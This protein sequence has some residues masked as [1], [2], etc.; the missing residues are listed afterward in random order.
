MDH[1]NTRSN[2]VAALAQQLVNAQKDT[3]LA[4]PAA[5]FAE[6][7]REGAFEVQRMTM[8][9]L[10]ERAAA[11]KIALEPSGQP[12]AAPIYASMTYA[13]PAR[14]A[15]PHRG[16]IGIEVEIAV[17]LA[18]SITPEMAARGGAGIM[19]SIESFH[20]GIELV[21]SRL[22]DRTEAG[23]YG[24]LADNLNTA[25]YV[26][27]EAQ[28]QRGADLDDVQVFLEIDDDPIVISPG[29]HPF[30]GVLETI[31]AYGRALPDQFGA[32][33][34]GMLVTTGALTGLIGLARPARVRA[35]IRSA[36][37]IHLELLSLV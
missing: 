26:W 15:L 1:K 30:G 4:V 19:P 14:I 22:D 37:P 18:E 21:G 27:S 3:A 28:W 32:L 20:V 10:G 9:R 7:D 24:Q 35:G 5:A 2:E 23:P 6:I 29:K 16:F 36:E 8:D 31:V 34:A 13:Q 17:R 33:E 25:G 12:I 11:S